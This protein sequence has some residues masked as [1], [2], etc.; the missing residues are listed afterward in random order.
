MFCNG[1]CL[2][3]GNNAVRIAHFLQAGILFQQF[4][5]SIVLQNAR[6][7]A[8]ANRSIHSTIMMQKDKI[9]LPITTF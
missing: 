7:G 2:C 5:R 6:Q 4:W 8:S 1:Y 9:R 3:Y